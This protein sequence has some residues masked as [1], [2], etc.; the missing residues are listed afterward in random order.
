MQL[1]IAGKKSEMW[2]V[3]STA[4][5]WILQKLFGIFLIRHRR[6]GFDTYTSNNE[7]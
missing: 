3:S 7:N 1:R 5:G 2:S 4:K 6:E